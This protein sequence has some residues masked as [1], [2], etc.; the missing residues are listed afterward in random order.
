MNLVGIDVSGRQLSKLRNGHKVRVKHGSGF[1]LVVHPE[2]YH[3]VHR[4]F[5]KGK[6]T[7]IKL[8]PEEIEDNASLSPEAHAELKD[9]SPM[10][11]IEGGSIFGKLKK[12]SKS[13][14]GKMAKRMAYEMAADKAHEG[15][16]KAHA[17]ASEYTGGNEYAQGMLNEYANKATHHIEKNRAPI[18]QRGGSIYKQIKKGLTGKTAKSIYK[19]TKP[20]RQAAYEMASEKLNDYISQGQNNAM[21]MAGDNPYAQGMV[22]NY[23]NQ[24]RNH[25]E[26]NRAPPA[27]RYMYGHGLGAG[28][29]G[30]NAHDALRLASLANAQ[31]NHKLA[32]M[33]NASV[34]G[35]MTQPPIK[36][37]WDDP[38]EPRSRGTG[39]RGHNLNFIR[40][41]GSLLSDEGALPPAL[42]S[43]PYGANFQFQHFLPPE[44]SRYNTGGSMEGNGLYI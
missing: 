15:I 36:H 44:Y 13:K 8:T 26:R 17:K 29:G 35:Q 10:A 11:A 24:A 1:N 25:V 7:D 39:M 40:G 42:R 27:D 34:H 30:M 41:R 37:Y 14:H 2:N 9:A 12:A 38:M 6:A 18:D 43:Q 31:A 21:N 33:H 22:Q 23:G 28:V 19:H 3:L 20:L 32:Q 16:A 4:A 5:T